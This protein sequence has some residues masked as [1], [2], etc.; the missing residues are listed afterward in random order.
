[1]TILSGRTEEKEILLSALASPSSE[2]IAVL[3]RRRV[4]K[5]FLIKQVYPQLD[6]EFT[7]VLNAPVTEQLE[8]FTQKLVEYGT[9]KK[10]ITKPV[11]WLQ[12]FAL[13]KK[14]LQAK[15]SKRK[16]I[17]FID[18][19]PWLDT[20]KARFTE[21]LGYFWNDY[22]AAN[23]IVIV[24]CGS[25]A[26]WMIRKVVHN[27][28]GLHNRITKL[29]DV[30]PF[31]L[32]ETEQFF[33]AANIAFSRYD[34]AQLY[35]IMGGIPY[36]LNEVK[37]GASVAQ[38]IDRICFQKNGLLNTEFEKLY[39]SLFSN[40]ENHITI[41]KALAGRWKGLTRKDIVTITK[42]T[43]GGN[44][45]KVLEELEMS[46]FIST[47]HP[48]GKI[49]KDKIFRLAD[50]YSL[51]YLH[52]IARQKKA[53]KGTFINMAK[54]AK[55]QS[56]CGYAFEN[57]C[58][59]HLDKIIKALGVAAIYTETAGYIQRG[60][61]ENQG[62]QIDLLIDRADRIINIC[63]IKFYDA[64]FTITKEYAAKLRLAIAKFREATKTRKTL[65]LTMI[66]TFGV[67]KNMH[68]AELVQ[69]EITLNDLFN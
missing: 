46:S 66:T 11:N 13:L 68:A 37:K 40:A 3:G 59:G 39:S 62:V 51:F 28:G 61:D 63:E 50:P 38:N 22:A 17:I 65:L 34:I 18:E 69:N 54:M 8:N 12:A 14:L 4:G 33:K 44:I 16:K 52:F 56:W 9:L 36:Y 55:W 30:K 49:K 7:G 60:N 27:K 20:P 41:V 29:I 23:N 5:T 47:T 19:L 58:V 6:F 35:M 45:T 10:T 32:K 43:D 53:A 48:F 21:A 25:A 57:I 31:T 24:I 1:M 26:S 2:M 64:P 67:E 42:L 15:K